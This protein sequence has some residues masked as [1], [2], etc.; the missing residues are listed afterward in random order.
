ML[1]VPNQERMYWF[2]E[3][4]CCHELQVDNSAIR[5]QVEKRL[6][7]HRSSNPRLN[8]GLRK[9]YQLQ[10]HKKQLDKTVSLLESSSTSNGI[11]V[12][13]QL[14][15]PAVNQ[16]PKYTDDKLLIMVDIMIQEHIQYWKR[17]PTQ[18]SHDF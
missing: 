6:K 9:L 13:Q 14:P 17:S 10:R 15:K 1:S 8:Q 7:S 3:D 2:V 18:K 16:L 4:K 5:A 12:G 11:D